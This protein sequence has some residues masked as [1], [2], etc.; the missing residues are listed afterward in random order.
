M[1]DVSVDVDLMVKIL[2]RGK[3][4]TKINNS[5]SLKTQ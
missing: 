2:T 4:G 3:D 1:S 5:V